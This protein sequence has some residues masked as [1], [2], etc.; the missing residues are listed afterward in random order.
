M[1]K[2][3]P[4]PNKPATAG[5]TDGYVDIFGSLSFHGENTVCWVPKYIHFLAI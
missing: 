5:Q 3:E 1:I 4:G 2:F